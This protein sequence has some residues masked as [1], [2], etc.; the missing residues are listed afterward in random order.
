MICG[1]AEQLRLNSKPENRVHKC[2]RNGSMVMNI[3]ADITTELGAR[4]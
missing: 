1:V 2:D 3:G 4:V